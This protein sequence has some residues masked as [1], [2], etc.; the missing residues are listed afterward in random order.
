MAHTFDI[1]FV[2]SSGLAGLFEAPANVFGWRGSGLLSI[3]TQ[4]MRIEVK[5]SLASLL[6]RQ[7]SQ[8]IPAENIREVYREGEALRIEFAS[9][10]DTRASIPFWARDRET[11]AQIVNLLPTSRT[12]EIEHETQGMRGGSVSKRM[13]L[14]LLLFVAAI[15]GAPFLLL[16]DSQDDATPSSQSAAVISADQEDTAATVPTLEIPPEIGLAPASPPAETPHATTPEETIQEPVA[17]SASPVVPAAAV[18]EVAPPRAT[19]QGEAPKE[20]QDTHSEEGFVPNIPE[21]EIR[22]ADL[23]VPI[24]QGTLAYDSARSLLARFEEGARDLSEGYRRQRQLSDSGRLSPAKF[25]D[26]LDSFAGRWRELSASL[27]HARDAVDPALTG[28]RG[29]LLSVASYQGSFLTAYA[30]AVRR[31]DAAATEKAFEDL[32]RADELLERA[33]LYIR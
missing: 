32:A 3:D 11:A 31:A 27:L 20:S 13:K 23:V 18:T 7:R 22:S 5:R 4:G 26:S 24:R 10:T 1:R 30:A 2:R 21:I 9:D 29:T 12:V 14:L 28:L 15:C 25:A 17:E 19:P 8:S 16:R 33:R 6:A